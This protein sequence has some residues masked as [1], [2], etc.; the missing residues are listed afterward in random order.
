MTTLAIPALLLAVFSFGPW[1][2]AAPATDAQ[3]IF[4]LGNAALRAGR[5]DEAAE[6]YR[7]TLAIDPQYETGH[8]NLG[9]VH[10]RRGELPQAIKEFRAEIAAYPESAKAYANLCS[11]LGLQNRYM[12]AAQAGETALRLDPENSTAILNLSKIWWSLNKPQRA[13][14]I[15]ETAS[16]E[17]KNSPAGRDALGGTYLKMNRFAE[18]EE[19]LRPLAEG[20]VQL[21]P[22]KLQGIDQLAYKEE[23]GYDKLK[24]HRAR[25]NYNL[26]WMSAMQGNESRALEYFQQAIIILPDFD[27]A[28]A[29]IGAAFIDRGLPDS[30]M[31]HFRRAVEIDST[32]AGYVYNVGIAWLNLGDTAA[33]IRE[34]ERSL[35]LDRNFSSAARKLRA[36][37]EGKSP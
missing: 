36:L 9:V 23:L 26:G 8:L 24:E 28:H 27:E 19:V 5:L 16:D 20:E 34:F 18:T 3:S 31:A 12:D 14:S 10:L 35:E 30:A 32:N 29:N 33:A 2:Q 25:A 7:Q 17:L 37:R 13:L 6:H 15:L 4:Q 21:D 1:Y 11:V 22:T